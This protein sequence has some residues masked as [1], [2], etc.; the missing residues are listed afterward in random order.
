MDKNQKEFQDI[1]VY[2]G[3]I[4]S[5]NLDMIKRLKEEHEEIKKRSASDSKHMLDLK[6]KNTKLP[7]EL[8]LYEVDKK[9]LAEVKEKIKEQ[10]KTY[11]RLQFQQEAL[12]QYTE[13]VQ[14]ERDDVYDR[15]SK[16]V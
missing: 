4:T 16:S 6:Q 5:S 10:E 13:R 15:F 14:M 11:S 2:Y 12:F 7:E 1:K 3:D 8:R 9:R